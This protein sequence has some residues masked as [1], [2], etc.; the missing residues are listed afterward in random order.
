MAEMGRPKIEFNV[1]LFEELCKLQ[2]TAIEIAAT[3]KMSVDT[4]ERRVKEH[5]NDTFAV[6]FDAKRESGKPSLRRAQWK[7]AIEK[8]DTVM[9]I[10]LGK[11]LLGQKDKIEVEDAREI[12]IK[13]G[14]ASD[15]EIADWAK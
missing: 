5:Y 8:D 10:W 7:K 2:C 3:M 11:N 4:L 6:V 13:L 1:E 12:T 9:Q 15:Q 14:G